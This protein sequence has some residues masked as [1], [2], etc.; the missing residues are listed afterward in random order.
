MEV[1]VGVGG[2]GGAAWQVLAVLV[3]VQPPAEIADADTCVLLMHYSHRFIR[4]SL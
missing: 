4:I 1:Y 2:T 3:G